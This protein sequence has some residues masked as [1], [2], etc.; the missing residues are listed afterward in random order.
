MARLGG[1]RAGGI[2]PPPP[3]PLNPWVTTRYGPLNFPIN[4]HDLPENYLK[5]LLRYDGGK[6]HST[7]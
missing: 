1:G 7:K 2:Q 6:T 4:V 3:P 5:I